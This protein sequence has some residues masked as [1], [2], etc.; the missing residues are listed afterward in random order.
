[1]KKETEG[2]TRIWKDIPCYWIRTDIVKLAPFPK[3]IYM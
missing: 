1:M 2:Y 3:V